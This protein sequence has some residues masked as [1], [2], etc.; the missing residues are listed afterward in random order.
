MGERIR[1]ETKAGFGKASCA[2]HLLPNVLVRIAQ[3]IEETAQ[4]LGKELK[5]VDLR[6]KQQNTT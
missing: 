5:H 1:T 3:H 4:I 6:K 2:A